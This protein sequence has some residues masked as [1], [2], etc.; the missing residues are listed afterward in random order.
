MQAQAR[1]EVFRDI[2]DRVDRD[3]AATRYSKEEL[4]VEHL[5]HRVERIVE[6]SARAIAVDGVG[7]LI[8]GVAVG[9]IL[10]GDDD[11]LLAHLHN[12][13]LLIL[14]VAR[15]SSPRYYV[16][17]CLEVGRRALLHTLLAALPRAA[18]VALDNRLKQ[19][20]DAI[21][22]KGVDG[23]VVVGRGDDNLSIDIYLVEDIEAYAV[24]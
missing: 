17:Q 9:D 6:K 18:K 23:I 5:L 3:D 10:Y 11:Y 24:G 12:K 20:V 14:L 1:A 15:S 13:A 22:A 2:L 8:L 4:R 7:A 16:E 19:V 21:D